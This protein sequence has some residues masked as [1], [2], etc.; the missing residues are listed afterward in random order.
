MNRLFIEPPMTLDRVA[1]LVSAEDR[2][3][4]SGLSPES[5]RR[6]FLT[7]RAIVRRELGAGVRIEYDASG[8]PSV[9]NV[10][11][12][13]DAS[14]APCV[15]GS[16]YHIGVTHCAGRVAVYICDARCAVDIEPESRDFSRV[17]PR[18]MSAGERALSDD[19]LLPAVVWCAKEALYKYAGR[20][21]LDFL[22]DLHIDMVD[23]AAGSVIGHIGPSAFGGCAEQ[24]TSSGHIERGMSAHHAEQGPPIRLS[25]RRAEGFIALCIP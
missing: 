14:E 15:V 19:A 25:I 18:Y 1:G 9:S 24:G 17:A 13:D 12:P 7:W 8:A 4:A 20:Q 16:K 11:I 5:R 2:A 10:R 6:E 21:G 23:L 3:L 22:H